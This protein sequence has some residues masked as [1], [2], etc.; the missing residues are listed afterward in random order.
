MAIFASQ[1]QN[2]DPAPYRHV[3][4]GARSRRYIEGQ[5]TSGWVFDP[6]P[7]YSNR[8]NPILAEFR[9]SSPWDI[10]HDA[11]VELKWLDHPARPVVDATPEHIDHARKV[12]QKLAA[13]AGSE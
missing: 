1:A 9:R 2:F 5:E 6:R 12:L 8:V 4:S 10:A 13:W 11:A 7:E 3:R